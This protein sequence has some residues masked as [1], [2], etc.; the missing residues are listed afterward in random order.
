MDV[1][2]REPVLQSEPAAQPEPEQSTVQPQPAAQPESAA[3]SAAQP[4]PAV[5]LGLQDVVSQPFLQSGAVPQAEVQDALIA[6]LKQVAAAQ[7]LTL[8]EVTEG[9]AMN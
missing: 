4:E 5:S 8:K 7:S 2:Q 3:Q 6:Y 9:T 1:A